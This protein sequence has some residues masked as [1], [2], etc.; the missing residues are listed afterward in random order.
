M[1][2]AIA[3]LGYVGLSLAI[4]LAK[5][6]Q[7]VAVDVVEDKVNM[8]NDRISPID[9][10]DFK[11]SLACEEL[12]LIAT[13]DEDKAYIDADYVIIAT[14]TN[15]DNKKNTF[16]TSA[17]ENV[18]EKVLKVNR[19]AIIVIKSTVPVGY[20]ES[21]SKKYNTDNILFS[22]EF[23]RES[24]AIYDNQKPSRII[25]GCDKSN[26]KMVNKAKEFAYVLKKSAFKKYV[27]I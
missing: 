13:M 22:P 16:D 15:Y 9:N 19:E 26:C 18:I 1:R 10:I 12:D 3:G 11:V 24:R 27:D 21:I 17:V 5:K 8:I 6:N 7:V 25:V 2:I 14:P 20:T 4:L 23:L